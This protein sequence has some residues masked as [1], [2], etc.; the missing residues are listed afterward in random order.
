MRCKSGEVHM[1]W[2]YEGPGKSTIEITA[3]IGFFT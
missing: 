2:I 1:R 3:Q